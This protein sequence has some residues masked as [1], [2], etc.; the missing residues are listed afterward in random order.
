MM[1][2]EWV[3]YNFDY[4]LVYVICKERNMNEVARIKE[5]LCVKKKS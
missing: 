1:E 4:P 5:I 3:A 2:Q